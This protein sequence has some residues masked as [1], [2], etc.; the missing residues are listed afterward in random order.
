MT[1]H[2]ECV[3]NR[4]CSSVQAEHPPSLI[5]LAYFAAAVSGIKFTWYLQEWSLPCL[6]GIRMVLDSS[7][8]SWLDW[9]QEQAERQF[10][11]IRHDD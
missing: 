3:A 9:P 5:I 4:Q 11:A 8:Q 1:M 7:M 6:Q 10:S 2:A